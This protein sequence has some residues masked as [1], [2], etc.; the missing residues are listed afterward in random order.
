VDEIAKR[1]ADAEAALATLDE[2]VAIRRRSRIE[3]DGTVLRLVYTFETTWQACQQLLAEHEK[4][5]TD[6]A[7]QT[8]QAAHRLGWLS[9]DEIEA[10]NKILHDR[11]LVAHSYRDEIGNGSWFIPP[12][13]VAGSKICG[14]EHALDE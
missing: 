1:L 8:I 7:N 10:I 14:S 9:R 2:A 12:R 5:A 13:S 3:R 11:N 6:T 4:I